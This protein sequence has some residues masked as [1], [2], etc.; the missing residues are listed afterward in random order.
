[1]ETLLGIVPDPCL[2]ERPMAIQGAARSL[3]HV[4]CLI[5]FVSSLA[6]LAK[7]QAVVGRTSLI[8]KASQPYLPRSMSSHEECTVVIMRPQ[9]WWA[10][11]LCDGGGWLMGFSCA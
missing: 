3:V 10:L 9:Q 7:P 2:F 5:V 6:L 4:F 8:K 1:M 11:D